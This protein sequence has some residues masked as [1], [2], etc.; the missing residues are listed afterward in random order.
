[1]HAELGRLE[2]STEILL[3][4]ELLLANRRANFINTS[5][6]LPLPG[7]EEFTLRIAEFEK[8]PEV[9]TDMGPS[10]HERYRRINTDHADCNRL[11]KS[12]STSTM[13]RS[14]VTKFQSCD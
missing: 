13:T 4:P 3:L 5:G 11:I 8:A 6:R 10:H 12:A 9:T 14:V 7:N 2:A 1:M